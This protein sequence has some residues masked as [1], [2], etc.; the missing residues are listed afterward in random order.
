MAFNNLHEVKV[1]QRV[2]VYKSGKIIDVAEV[3]KVRQRTVDIWNHGEFSIH[4]G[5]KTGN[6]SNMLVQ[7]VRASAEEIAVAESHLARELE[8]QEAERERQRRAEYDALPEEVKLAKK[9]YGFFQFGGTEKKIA[10]MPIELLR[11]VAQW[12]EENKFECE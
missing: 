3:R 7:A 5:K 4:S 9:V 8:E 11:G 2:I 12:I 10:T 6:G 1:G